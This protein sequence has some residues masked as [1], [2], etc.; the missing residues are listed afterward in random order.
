MIFGWGGRR[1]RQTNL[2]GSKA[3]TERKGMC[4]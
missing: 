1:A 4:K 3:G 2:G